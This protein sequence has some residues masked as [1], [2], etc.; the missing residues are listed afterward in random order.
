MFEV[1]YIKNL[2][3]FDNCGHLN[4]V[5]TSLQSLFAL[6][7]NDFFTEVPTVGKHNKIEFQGHL[8]TYDRTHT[9]GKKYYRCTKKHCKVNYSHIVCMYSSF[10]HLKFSL[11]LFFV[12]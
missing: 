1:I 12:A 7:M 8:L 5:F 10:Q 2:K 9:S 4:S 6:N 3:N 11:S